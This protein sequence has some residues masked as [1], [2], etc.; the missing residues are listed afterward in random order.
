MRRIAM[1]LLST[2][3]FAGLN[4][5]AEAAD[6]KVLKAKPITKAP[7]PQPSSGG[8]GFYVGINGGYDWSRVSFIDFPVA[9]STARLQSGMAGLT[10][11]Y[12]AQAGSVVY[13]IETDIDAAWM[14]TTNW[15]FPPCF[16]CEVQLRY[17]GTLRGRLGYAM[18]QSLPYITGG[19]AYGG[20][21]VSSLF[22]GTTQND[23]RIGWTA[24]GGI[25]H[26]LQ[27]GWSVKAEYLYYELDNMD[28]GP[29]VCGTLTAV[30]FKGNMARFGTNYR[31]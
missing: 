22:F 29:L 8:S 4:S 10:F 2:V 19:M 25:E 6:K 11:G 7:P 18:G 9:G 17:F 5:L 12:N 13:G 1:L 16:A 28:C 24:G 26:A 21:S 15:G 14:K 30:K 20:T 3:A 31:F 27:G 23:T